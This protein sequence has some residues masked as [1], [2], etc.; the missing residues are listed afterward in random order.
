MKFNP[1]DFEFL[2][3]DSIRKVKKETIMYDLE[4]EDDHT[5]YVSKNKKDD[6]LVHN[7]DGNHIRGLLMNLIDVYWPELL[8]MNFLYDFI[9][10]IIKASK[11]K[12]VKYY[13][14]LDDYKKDKDKLIGYDIKWI[15][16]L[17]TIQPQEMKE[18]FRKIDK[19]LIRFHYD[20]TETP[21]LFDM[22]F[23]NK[24]S[25]D[26]KEWLKTYSPVD[27]SDKFSMKQTYDKFINNEYI[28]FSMYNNVR[29]IPNVVDG[30]KPGQRKA[31][32]TL[33]K[34]NIKNEIKVSSL[35]GAV[36]ES[37]AYHHG[38]CLDYDTEILLGDG[39]KIK[40]GDWA[41]RYPN[42]ELIV[43]CIDE[44]NNLVKSIGKHPVC[45][46]ITNEYYEIYLENNVK[47]ICTP[48]HKFYVNNEWIEAKNLQ[49][50]DEILDLTQI[51]KN[52]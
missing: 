20:K 27:F 10:P 31:F 17:G 5:F 26:R 52:D 39:N 24:R 7:C 36:I 46:T 32:Y 22:L 48:E 30:F 47:I 15:K 38:N 8:K 51:M 23:N 50:D 34:K 4:V 41:S 14:K 28:E 44:N 21:E 29:Q 37:A 13:Y 45:N 6:I 40:I 18:F 42:V 19:H 3:I 49:E 25:D 43:Y 11:G 2:E 9:T 35:S 16:G 33:I 1:N 12:V